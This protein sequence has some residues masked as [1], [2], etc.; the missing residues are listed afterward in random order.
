MRISRADGKHDGESVAEVPPACV[1]V[2]HVWIHQP[3]R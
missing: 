2:S 3:K 1:D